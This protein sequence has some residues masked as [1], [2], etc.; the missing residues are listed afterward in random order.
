MTSIIKNT[1]EYPVIELDDR[2]PDVSWAHHLA[3]KSPGGVD[4]AYPYGTKVKSPA[5]GRWTYQAGSGGPEN[6]GGN[7]GTLHLDDGRKIEFMHLSAN[8]LAQNSRVAIGDVLALSGGSGFGDLRHYPAHLHVHIVEID[9]TRT[10]LFHAFTAIVKAASNPAFVVAMPGLKGRL[11]IQR[12][13]FK[14][15]RITRLQSLSPRWT[16][17]IIK[18]IQLTA[19][20]V[21]YTGDIDGEFGYWTCHFVQVYAKKW[22]GYTGKIDSIL[23]AGSWGGFAIGVGKK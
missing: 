5:A 13:L 3:R 9:G 7:I 18:A 19:K 20:N 17:T 21:G 16:P 10:N 22:G 4:L 6:S 8:I 11:W 1:F 15:G 14:H 23:G 12:G 2:N